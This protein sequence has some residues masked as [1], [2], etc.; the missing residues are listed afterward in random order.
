MHGTGTQRLSDVN[1]TLSPCMKVLHMDT[2]HSCKTAINRY[3]FRK[4]FYS[5]S[6][7]WHKAMHLDL[8]E[9]SIYPLAQ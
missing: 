3:F 9:L 8:A 6:L 4:I 1:L 2:E 7:N 5:R